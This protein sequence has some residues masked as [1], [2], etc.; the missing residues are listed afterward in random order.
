MADE[1]TASG[2]VRLDVIPFID[3]TH[4]DSYDMTAHISELAAKD[5]NAVF[6]S[7]NGV[8]AV[9]A[10]LGGKDTKWKIFCLGNKTKNTVYQYFDK[11]K[12]L[13]ECDN[14]QQLAD[15][16]IGLRVKDVTFFCGDSRMDILPHALAGAGVK[17][18]ELVVYNTTET[19]HV[20]STGYDGV[21]F[22]SPSAV[23]SF[24]SVNTLGADAVLFAIGDTTAAEIMRYSKAKIIISPSP[25]KEEMIN[26]VVN[27]FFIK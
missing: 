11:N 4:V 19:P 5:L 20:I 6:T 10:M 23:R 25:S 16:L 15:M 26:D 1:A 7:S 13:S 21:L 12:I 2:K 24:F 3:I 18:E 17:V 9:A 27:Y 8:E 22:F 14:A